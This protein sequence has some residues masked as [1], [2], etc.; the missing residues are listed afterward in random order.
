MGNERKINVGSGCDDWW[1][2]V[3]QRSYRLYIQLQ[4]LKYER[5]SPRKLYTDTLDRF[6]IAGACISSPQA[7]THKAVAPRFGEEKLTEMRLEEASLI[8]GRGEPGH[9]AYSV[10]TT[11]P[12]AVVDRSH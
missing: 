7:K 5:S 11:L 9:L 3:Q 8:E 2:R 10:G 6:L 4:K 12:Y 1:S